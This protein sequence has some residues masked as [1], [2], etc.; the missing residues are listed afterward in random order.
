MRQK[1]FVLYY[2]SITLLILSFSLLIT[3]LPNK[4]L[5]ASLHM[6]KLNNFKLKYIVHGK[7]RTTDEV[8]FRAKPCALS[9]II[10]YNPKKQETLTL[11]MNY[12]Y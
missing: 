8:F 3:I 1:M 12:Y 11:E 9:T 4:Y 10:H 2:I 5:I 7:V 6:I